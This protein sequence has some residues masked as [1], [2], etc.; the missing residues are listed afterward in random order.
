METVSPS[1]QI[2]NGTLTP[3]AAIRLRVDLTS[4]YKGSEDIYTCFWKNFFAIVIKG[5]DIIKTVRVIQAV[6]IILFSFVTLN[7]E[8][9]IFLENAH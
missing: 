3:F 9:S 1:L 4:V 8:H 2:K 7:I 5:C 6:C